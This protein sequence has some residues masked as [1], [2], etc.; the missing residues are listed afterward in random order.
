MKHL[1]SSDLK[2]LRSSR[3]NYIPNQNLNDMKTFNFILENEYNKSKI[4]E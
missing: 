3:H 2:S 1:I 4:F